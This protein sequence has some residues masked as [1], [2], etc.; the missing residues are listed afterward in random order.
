MG[1]K[2]NFSLAMRRPLGAIAPRS[3]AIVVGGKLRDVPVAHLAARELAVARGGIE[4]R[5]RP[6]PE[7][8]VVRED[9]GGW[10]VEVAEPVVRGRALD[11]EGTGM[12][13]AGGAKHREAHHAPGEGMVVRLAVG[14]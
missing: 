5:A 13:R 8:A 7:A 10:R 1:M 4:H 3:A 2:P 14:V 11:G 12:E 9:L 6:G